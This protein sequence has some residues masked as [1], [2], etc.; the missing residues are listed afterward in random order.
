L[1]FDPVPIATF[2]AAGISGGFL[3]TD[4]ATVTD[5]PQPTLA[6]GAG[7]V[8]VAFE[9]P[10]SG[11]IMAAGARVVGLG[12][13]AVDPFTLP[14]A[15]TRSQTGKFADIA[16]GPAGQVMVTYEILRNDPDAKAE[17]STFGG[18]IFINPDGSF[19]LGG[20]Q[21]EESGA[22]EIFVNVDPDGLGPAPFGRRFKATDTNIGLFD[23]ISAQSDKR[24]DAAPGI[25]YDRSG[26]PFNGRAY[27]VYTDEPR[28]DVDDNTD[29]FVRFS[30][31]DGRTWSSPR[32]VNDDA[33][34]SG[35]QFLPRIAM[36]QTTG[37]IA[38]SWYDTRFENNLSFGPNDETQVFVTVGVPTVAEAGVQFAG[39]FQASQGFSDANR[40]RSIM[41]FGEYMGL[42]FHENVVYPVWAD[43]SNSLGDNPSGGVITGSSLATLDLYATRVIVTAAEPVQPERAPVGPGSPLTPRFIGRDTIT[44]GKFYRFQVRYESANGIDLQSLGDDDLLVTGPVG[45]N[46]FA[47]FQKAKRGRGGTIATATYLAP[48]PGGKF[49]QGDNGLYSILVQG[50][51]VRDLTGTQTAPGLLDQFLVSSDLPPQSPPN[52]PAAPASAPL[53]P[54]AADAGDDDDSIIKAG[55]L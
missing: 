19:S 18:V 37:N 24:I 23:P 35:S 39:N 50:G 11:E 31:D 38:V 36:D 8:W 54:A 53:Q 14:Q 10:V 13:N 22:A 33:F 1:S 12:R 43:N 51:A 5:S 34:V 45:Y 20:G 9:D 4:L 16:I 26:G 48:A 25:V 44:K 52:L 28:N 30:D 2:D 55:G 29:V 47:D 27:M 6:V 7:S 46:L 40:A 15:A 41:D 17:D 21:E 3:D 49:D 42:D 32:T